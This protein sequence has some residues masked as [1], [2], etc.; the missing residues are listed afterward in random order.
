MR[1]HNAVVQTAAE[2]DR[3]PGRWLK[4]MELKM[5]AAERYNASTLIDANLAAGRGAHTALFFGDERISYDELFAR[6][7][8]MGWLL[9]EWGIERENRVLLVLGD[10]P[11]FPVAFF[12]ALRIGAVPVAVNPLYKASDYQFFLTDSDA[13]LVV[14]DAAQLDKVNEAIAAHGASVNIIVAEE[15]N[16]LL[17]EQ[18]TML[19]PADTHRDDMAFWLYSSGST[20]NPKGVVHLHRNLS[21]TCETYG[22]HVLELTEHDIVFGRVL[23]HAYGLGNALSF[24]F[25]AGAASVLVPGRLAPRGLLDAIACYHPTVLCLVP[26][27]YNAILNE[28]DGG[29]LSSVRR[30]ISA[31]EPL[32]PE[33]WRRWKDKYGLEIL[34]GIGSTEMLHIFCSNT[35]QACRPGSSGRPVPG[36]ELKILDDNGHD[37]ADGETGNLFVKGPSAAA[38]YWRN[39]EKTQHTMRGEWMATGDRYR[40]DDDGFYWYEGRADDMLKVGGEWVSPIEIENALLEHPAVN[41]AAVVGVT[42]EGVMRIRAV[43]ILHGAATP[44]L[45]T[46]LQQWCKERLQRYQYPHRIDFVTE[47]PKTASGKI[48]RFK[49]REEWLP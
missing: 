19:I 49:L 6:V 32:A 20:G 18:D 29:D 13:R 26:T 5:I 25:C 40:C 15:L 38:F 42:L 16:E 7:C 2:N 22:K 12:G 47:L 27:L 23:F 10:T 36:Y 11:A 43:I 35:A 37:V 41:E 17:A 8:A 45:K 39:R 9:H 14:T 3:V 48:Q 34:D 44:T 31:A 46:E 28:S 21:A 4:T 1:A 30:C 24:P 33:T